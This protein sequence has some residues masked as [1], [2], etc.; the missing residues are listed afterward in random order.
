M[1]GFMER[2]IVGS[3][4]VLTLT[5]EKVEQFVEELVKKGEVARKDQPKFVKS[6]IEKGKNART[7]LEQI[8]EK[9]TKNVL[10]KLDIPTRSDMDALAKKIE[11]LEKKMKK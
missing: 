4:G 8:V 1:E 3:L 6:L 10:R 5:R 11:K 9:V 7:E 2:I